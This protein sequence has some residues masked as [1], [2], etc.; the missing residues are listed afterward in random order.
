[1]YKL[2]RPLCW[3]GTSFS[4]TKHMG[5]R[6]YNRINWMFKVVL[7]LL[8]CWSYY[9]W[10]I[11]TDIKHAKQGC[12]DLCVIRICILFNADREWHGRKD[13][14]GVEIKCPFLLKECVCGQAELWGPIIVSLMCQN[15]VLSKHVE[16][17][18]HTSRWKVDLRRAS[19][20]ESPGSFC[21]MS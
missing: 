8:C 20:R 13:S 6:N 9:I 16:L 12:I 7:T 5:D 19:A 14:D 2:R 21:T 10:V 11:S 4:F 1:M 3:G 17:S 18:H 15:K